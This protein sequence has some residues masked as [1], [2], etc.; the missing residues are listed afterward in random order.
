MNKISNFTKVY[1]QNIMQILKYL[2][3][4]LLLSLVA[5]TIFVATQKGEFQLER[6]K[7]INAPKTAVFNY[8]NDYQ[9]WPNFN[10]WMLDDNN[11]KMTYPAITSGKGASCSWTGADGTGD[12]QTTTLKNNENITQKLNNNGTESEVFWYFKDTVGGTKVTWKT[13]GNLSFELKMY[14]TL[15]GGVERNIGSVYEKSLKN[16]DKVLDYETNTYNVKVIGEV[17]KTA[18][19]YLS[20]SFH[21]KVSNINKNSRIVF[22]KINEYCEKNGIEVYGK[23]FIIYH[24][25]DATKEIAK[26]TFCIPVKSEIFSTSDKDIIPGKLASFPAIKT[27]LKGDYSH[28]PKAL[29]Q[30]DTY[31]TNKAIRRDTKFSHIEVYSIGKNESRQPSKWVT[32]IY[33]P[34]QPKVIPT[35]IVRT[36]QPKKTVTETPAKEEIPSEF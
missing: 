28:L 5:T 14:A 11:L 19:F 25:Y 22:S 24:N 17:R 31:F 32:F 27:T 9:N 2:F 1:I 13:K 33:S 15:K 16:L 34:I 30:T 26:L 12:I 36:I 20:Q 29:T 23:P 8:V 21:S 4:L 6:S 10:S 35:P 18:T 7:I 3:L